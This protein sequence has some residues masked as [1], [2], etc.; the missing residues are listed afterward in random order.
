MYKKS[1]M[2][3]L[4]QLSLSKINCRHVSVLPSVSKVFK[5]FLQHQLVNYIE[6]YLSLHLYGY[7]KGHSSQQALISLRENWKKSLDKKGYFGAV[8]LDLSKAFDTIKH[9]L[10]LEK[11][12]A[13]G[14]S[15]KALKLVHN[16]FRNR[17]NRTKINTDFS[18]WQEL[19]EGV[20]QGS[21]LASSF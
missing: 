12:H 10:L 20:T 16:H 11:L 7:R 15:K 5:K 9:D 13:Y 21:V 6:N 17:W 1:L 19:L 2:S 3:Q 14:F 8:L 18:T 4:R